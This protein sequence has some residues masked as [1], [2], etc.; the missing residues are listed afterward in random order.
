MLYIYNIYISFSTSF[1][2]EIKKIIFKTKELKRLYSI[3][4]PNTKYKLDDI[5][6][7][8]IYVL[9]TGISWRSIRTHINFR[10]LYFHFKRFIKY[11]VFGRLFK[12]IRN[13]Y[14]KK[15]NTNTTYI[16]DSS[17]IMN[18]CGK[19]KISRN[20]FFKNKNCNKI[21]LIT[22]D[23]GI[24]LSVLVN[25][26]TVH[27]ITFINKHYNDLII[28]LIEFIIDANLYPTSCS[29]LFG[30]QNI[31]HFIYPILLDNMFQVN[32]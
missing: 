19:N 10:T 16:I 30:I 25:K 27:D 6:N 28:F 4:H 1:I 21:S 13:T 8:I 24:P 12:K 11:D 9:K 14:I 31:S 23:N 18:I 29:Y 17:F 20:K 5:L 15:N 2:N 32:P 26:G 22:D 7:D 3:K